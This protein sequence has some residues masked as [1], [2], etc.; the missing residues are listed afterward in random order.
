MG[1]ITSITD[2]SG[3]DAAKTVVFT[4]DDLYRLTTASTTAANS[5]PYLESYGYDALGNFTSKTGQGTYTYAGTNYANPH[6]ATQIATGLATTTLAYDNNGNL[7]G[8]GSWTYSWDYRN[9]LT[10][11]SNG[12]ASTYAYDN[13]NQ[14]VMKTVAGATTIYPNKYFNKTGATTTVHIFLSDGSL[15]ATVEGNGTATTTSYIHVDHLGST[16][17][18]TDGDGNT[19]EV[20]DYYPYGSERIDSGTANAEQRTFI[21][22]NF[23]T[24]TDLSYLNAR[25]YKGTQGQFLSQDATFLAVGDE[26]RLK[27]V[28]GLDQKAILADPQV[29][30]SY[31]YAKDNPMTNKDPDG[32]F[33]IALPIYYA[34]ATA[35]GWGPSIAVG[36]LGAAAYITADISLRSNG[37][38]RLIP[39]NQQGREVQLPGVPDP[40]NP[41][42]G[43]KPGTPD[44]WKTWVGAGLTVIGVAAERYKEAQE[45][46]ENTKII[47]PTVNAAPA[48]TDKTKNSG[49]QDNPKTNSTPQQSSVSSPQPPSKKR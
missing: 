20:L 14:R 6:A 35:P 18:T 15:V 31:S 1:N 37:G 17:V 30:N 36:V 19:T 11:A 49:T 10:Q 9:R 39:F 48:N 4:Y 5:T 12:A 13:E 44:N 34:A 3:T 22:Q 33:L 25:Y 46:K 21:G 8:A 26:N 41:W 40:L 38:M 24:E 47:Q 7:T 29:L 43:W 27:Q 28:T 45:F 23:D 2:C 32:K 16:N 42:D